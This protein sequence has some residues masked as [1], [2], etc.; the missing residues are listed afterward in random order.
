VSF[1]WCTP[2]IKELF[3][4]PSAT[5]EVSTFYM[6][7]P[8]T[9]ATPPKSKTTPKPKPSGGC[10]T[11]HTHKN[12]LLNHNFFYTTMAIISPF[13]VIN[14]SKAVSVPIGLNYPVQ[15]AMELWITKIDSCFLEPIVEAALLSC[16]VGFR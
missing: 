6:A 3:E 7:T 8:N 13:L 14:T 11:T 5:W 12:P 4:T 16:K 1:L 10:P 15:L 9:V 2:S